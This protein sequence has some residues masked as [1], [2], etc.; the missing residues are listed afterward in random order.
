MAIRI[1]CIKKSNGYHENPY[2]AIESLGWVNEA[3]NSTGRN[4]RLEI[5][6]WIE[7]EKGE[8]YV[9]DNLGNKAYL[10][11]AES[12][13]GTKYVKTKSDDVTSDNPLNLPECQ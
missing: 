13:Y 5:Y 11:V 1:I 4:S 8:A 9:K 7:F 12:G 6:N 2:T 10:I 3:T